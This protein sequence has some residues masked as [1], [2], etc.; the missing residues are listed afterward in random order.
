[1]YYRIYNN[2]LIKVY[3]RVDLANSEVVSQLKDK[4]LAGFTIRNKNNEIIFY[5]SEK[6]SAKELQLL[7][8]NLD[9][10]TIALI[11]SKKE[12]EDYFYLEVKVQFIEYNRKRCTDS[13]LHEWLKKSMDARIAKSKVWRDVKK[14]VYKRLKNSGFLVTF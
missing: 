12:I 5:D 6:V 4:N 13:E 7:I 1:M 2:Q 14:E 10:A 9:T 3:E 11:M 8:R